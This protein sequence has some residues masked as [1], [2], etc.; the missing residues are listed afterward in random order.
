M[1]KEKIINQLCRE[2][3]GLDLA[4]LRFLLDMVRR[5]KPEH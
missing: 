5:L 1:A 2:I 4:A 3:E